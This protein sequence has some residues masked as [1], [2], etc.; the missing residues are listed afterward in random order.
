MR[1]PMSRIF[2]VSPAL[3]SANNGN[4]QTAHR[5][6][7]FLHEDYRVSLGAQWTPA[8]Q[9]QELPACL[10]ALH[11]RRS[12][13][14]IVRFADACPGRPLVV[15]LT[16]TDLYRDIRTDETARHSLDL[17]SHLVVLQE[18]GLAEMTAAYRA[19]CRVIY[20]SAP[21]RTSDVSSTRRR[22][23]FDVVLVGHMRA[24][25][26]PCTPMRSLD[27]LPDDS[28]VRLIHIGRALDDEYRIA[29]HALQAR[30]WRTVRRYVW[31]DGL[32]HGATLRRIANAQALIISS[33]MEGGANVIIEAVNAGVPV[34]ASHIPGNIGMLGR[35]YDGYFPLGDDKALARLLDRA[36]RDRAFLTTLQQQCAR[37]APLF[38]PALEEAQVIRLVTEAL[39]QR[40][41]DS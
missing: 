1:P 5:W 39:A 30:V 21:A 23:T 24:E 40:T 22:R 4:W 17:A 10:I 15:V 31:F 41:P 20:Q 32:P 11:A 12:A 6:S 29:A 18:E 33:V 9:P 25:K 14:S 36:S 35:D 19:K 28:R 2:I 27:H 7:R 26:D 16:G 38:A 13:P 8:D 3:R 34:L 37:R